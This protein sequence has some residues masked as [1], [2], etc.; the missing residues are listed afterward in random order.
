M[1]HSDSDYDSNNDINNIMHI[2]IYISYRLCLLDL[3]NT[4]VLNINL[5]AQT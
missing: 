5:E 3:S 1:L 4:V 2:Y